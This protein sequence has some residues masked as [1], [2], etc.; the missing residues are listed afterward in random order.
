MVRRGRAI[1]SRYSCSRSS[2]SSR[3]SRRRRKVRIRS[4]RSLKRM[5]VLVL[6]EMIVLE[7]TEGET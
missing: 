4:V 1:G 6:E 7:D 2:R 3:S 5:I